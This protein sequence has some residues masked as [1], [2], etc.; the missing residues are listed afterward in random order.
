M[1]PRVLSSSLSRKIRDED[2]D[3]LLAKKENMKVLT[4]KIGSSVLLTHR[5]KLDEFRVAHIADQVVTLR[6]QRIGVVLVVSGAVACGASHINFCSGDSESKMI[7]AGIG[8]AYVIS[9]FQ[10]IFSK[11]H[12][13][14]AQVLLTKDLLNIKSKKLSIR[15]LLQAYIELGVVPVIN[16]N[17]VIDLNSFGGND[18]LAADVS[19]LLNADQLMMLSTMAGSE[20]GVGGGEAKLKALE[21]LSRN[22]IQAN[23][24]DGKSK[25][26]ILQSII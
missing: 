22:N 1:V 19:I 7:A 15:R 3:F 6:E 2:E 24:V 9:I 20:Y 10:Q 21:I 12:L 4:I 13:Q 5:N 14:I 8:Q 11:K 17:D 23:I 26:S 18:F 16:E 25:N